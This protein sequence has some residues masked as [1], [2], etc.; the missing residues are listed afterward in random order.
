MDVAVQIIASGLTLGAMYAVAR[1][2]LS[3][4]YGSLNMLNMAHGALLALGGYVCFYVMTQIGLHPALA[5]VAAATI[6]CAVVGLVYL[7]R[8]GAAV[9]ELRQFRDQYL[10][11]HHRHR[12]HHRERDPEGLRPAS[13]AASLNLTGAL[14]IGNVYV[15]NQNLFYPRRRAGLMIALA[16]LLRQPASAARSARPPRTARRRS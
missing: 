14:V 6:V 9:A 1:S 7:C 11:R 13:A 3:L 5:R 8:R 15:P 12:R 4:V 2:C 10:H 16:L